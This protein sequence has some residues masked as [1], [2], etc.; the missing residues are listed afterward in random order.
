MN[1]LDA[2]ALA[3]AIRINP[4]SM[5]IQVVDNGDG[6]TKENMSY[7][8]VRY[9]TNKLRHSGDLEKTSK[10]YG[11]RGE[12]LA[13]IVE[14]S[15][16]VI[17]TSK[18][19]NSSETYS[20]EIEQEDCKIFQTKNRPSPGTTVT[21]EGFFSEF[22]VR[23]NR[24]NADVELEELKK[25]IQSLVIVRPNVSFSI[26][27][28]ITSELMVNS[29]K[30]NDIIS[31]F[32]YIHPEINEECSLLKITKHT[33]TVEALLF[34]GI[35]EKRL[36]YLYVNKRPV[37][38]NK[39][40]KFINDVFG[41]HQVNKKVNLLDSGNKFPIYVF[42]I[43][44]PYSQVDIIPEPAKTTVEFHEWE[45][46][47]RCIEK[48][49]FL[50]FGKDRIHKKRTDAALPITDHINDDCGVRHIQ[51]AFKTFGYKRPHNGK[52]DAA[53]NDFFM[54]AGEAKAG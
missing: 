18:F 52:N 2:K 41:K 8:G 43:R 39:I 3:I 1:S 5:R 44:C 33:V 50:F 21:V 42:N 23:Q 14:C 16:C 45:L 46:L 31:S 34:K 9:M 13:N 19:T 24:F 15:R 29:K 54:N 12:A 27:N 22:P 37:S 26:R 51:G 48:I 17:I 20:K 11:F 47:Y 35:A 53:D 30:C 25:Y 40:A 36:Q 6:I 28:D 38:S 32:K 10:Y 4:V 49:V 7:I